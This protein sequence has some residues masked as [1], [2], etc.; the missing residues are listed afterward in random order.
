MKV[1]RYRRAAHRLPDFYPRFPEQRHAKCGEQR[2]IVLGFSLLM[3]GFPRPESVLGFSFPWLK[4]DEHIDHV[5]R[6]LPQNAFAYSGPKTV[7]EI[8][9]CKRPHPG[10]N[11]L[12]FRR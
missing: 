5:D 11:V 3:I 7:F 12:R 6:L 4:T 1:L 9:R 8:V 10:R 2:I